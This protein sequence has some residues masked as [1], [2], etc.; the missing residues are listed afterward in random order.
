MGAGVKILDKAFGDERFS[1]AADV[2]KLLD[3]RG[4]PEADHA[5]ILIA[6]LWKQCTETQ[7]YTVTQQMVRAVLGTEGL[8]ALL[9]ADLAELVDAHM[10]TKWAAQ[11]GARATPP[12]AGE[13]LVRMRGTGG[14]I[15]WY[16]QVIVS[17]SFG[18]PATAKRKRAD[19]ETAGRRAGR[20]A[21]GE[22]VAEPSGRPVGAPDGEPGGS[23][24]GAP[25]SLS[26]L[27]SEE[28]DSPACAREDAR[29]VDEVVGGDEDLKTRVLC[30]WAALNAM[31]CRLATRFGLEPRTLR[32]D[33]PGLV[34]LAERLVSAPHRFD[35]DWSTVQDNLEAE[36][37]E[38]RSV[39]Y[40]TGAVFQPR[41]WRSLI[42]MDPGA[43]RRRARARRVGPGLRVVDGGTVEEANA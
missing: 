22:P 3:D 5:L 10:P 35:G 6:R 16:G 42:A 30:T 12:R 25:S 40:L 19:N 13:Q 38:L 37:I 29:S 36:A 43:A 7:H 27:S 26:S 9:I 14:E 28:S 18:G 4:R 20:P 24:H 8:D 1:I 2:M 23:P 15:E 33:D 17:A 41:S 11:I 32:P 34:D 21:G 39:E 31:R